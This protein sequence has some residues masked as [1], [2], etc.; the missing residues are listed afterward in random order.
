MLKLPDSR[1]LHT[2]SLPFVNKVWSG[3]LRP[4]EI[5]TLRYYRKTGDIKVVNLLEE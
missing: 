3:D 5:K 4:Y 1:F 2:I